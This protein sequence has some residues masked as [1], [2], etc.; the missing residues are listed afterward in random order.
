MTDAKR[1]TWEKYAQA[2]AVASA[3]DKLAALRDSVES[4][5]VYRDP[6]LTAEGHDALVDCMLNFHRQI[7]GGHF[8]T[9]YFQTHHD[10]SIAKWNMVD[11]QGKVIGDGISFGEYNDQGR[12]LTMTGFFESPGT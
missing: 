9:T 10:R 11:G 1:I 7:P 4:N 6:L 8:V 2:W 3:E 12:L 5:C